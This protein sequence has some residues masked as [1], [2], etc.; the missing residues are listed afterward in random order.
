MS[1]KSE[2]LTQLVG[3]KALTWALAIIALSAFIVAAPGLAS[4]A[5]WAGVPLALTYLVPV[6]WDGGLVVFAWASM[7]HKN[8][9]ESAK[10]AMFWMVLLVILSMSANVAHTLIPDEAEQSKLIAGSVVVGSLA[11]VVFASVHVILGIQLPARTRTRAAAVEAPAAAVRDAKTGPAVPAQVETPA[12]RALTVVKDPQPPAKPEAARPVRVAAHTEKPART[13][14]AGKPAAGP[15][16]EQRARVL[17]LKGGG[18]SLRQIETETGLTFSQVRTIVSK[19][20][21]TEAAA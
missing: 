5:A 9:G 17:E 14:T 6:V 2:Q 21:V 10:F 18:M 11:L 8:R 15:T 13:A 1:R 16:D 4:V 7:L 19:A 3:N 20:A 12:P